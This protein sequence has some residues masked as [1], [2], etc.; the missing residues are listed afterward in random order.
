MG[1]SLVLL[2]RVVLRDPEAWDG[3][4]GPDAVFLALGI[5]GGGA[6]VLLLVAVPALIGVLA[7]GKS[8][9]TATWLLIIPGV[10][11]LVGAAGAAGAL[12][13]LQPNGVVFLPTVA[14]PMAIS[15]LLA[16]IAGLLMRGSVRERAYGGPQPP[17][18]QWPPQQWPAQ[19][20]A[21]AQWPAPP[22][23]QPPP[24]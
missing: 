15:P 23:Q 19:P 6:L 9:G 12:V 21:Q 22:P 24:L 10:F 20:P 18:Q 17:P 2:L 11:G 7:A 4:R 8:R 13:A 3:G 1:T 16:F 14:G 5:L